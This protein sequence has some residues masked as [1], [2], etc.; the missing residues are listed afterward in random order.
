LLILVF[1]F[2]GFATARE[3]VRSQFLSRQ[4]DIVPLLKFHHPKRVLQHTIRKYG[5]EPVVSRLLK[6]TGRASLSPIFIV[7]VF[8]GAQKL[9]EG[10]GSSLK[11]ADFR[12]NEDALRRLYMT[13]NDTGSLPT[14]TLVDP[15]ATYVPR[16]LGDDE[17]AQ[18]SGAVFR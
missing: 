18:E 8:S 12:A 6:E 9:G 4:A 7:G 17:V 15:Q 13:K 10:F 2:Q 5:R 3:L 14:D 1:F 16:R 11:M